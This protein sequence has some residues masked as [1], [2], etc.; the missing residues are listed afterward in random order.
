MY[1]TY[2]ENTIQKLKNDT[3]N[4]T[5]QKQI[6]DRL[7]VTAGLVNA[8]DSICYEEQCDDF[9]A[10]CQSR[11][12]HFLDYFEKRHQGLLLAKVNL[13]QRLGRIEKN[14]DKQQL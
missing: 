9:K 11:A 8:N 1:K 4:K 10:F 5:K 3:C 6:L 7:F 2:L 14:V 12:L 13:P